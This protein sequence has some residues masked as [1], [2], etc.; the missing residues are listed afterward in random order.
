MDATARATK[1][2]LG[3]RLNLFRAR[4]FS[5]SSP[6]LRGHLKRVAWG[7]LVLGGLASVV[8]AV[9]PHSLWAS[10]ISGA[11]PHPAFQLGAQPSAFTQASS[12]RASETYA[13]SPLY[14]EAN[15]GQADSQ[16]KF[17]THGDRYGLF[18]TT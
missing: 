9:L 10:P 17:L 7:I 15:L 18:L 12:V 3:S 11:S 6:L 2:R 16:A 8:W 1:H 13:Q 14:F 5:L 4:K